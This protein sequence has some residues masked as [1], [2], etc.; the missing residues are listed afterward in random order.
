MKK[1]FIEHIAFLRSQGTFGILSVSGISGEFT[2]FTIERQWLENKENISRIPS[3]LYTLRID[4]FKGK[5]KNYK[6]LKVNNRTA[7]EMHIANFSSE[8]N[9]CIALGDSISWFSKEKRFGV[10]NSEK[11]FKKFMIAMNGDQEAILHI[12]GASEAML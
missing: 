4:T 12:F 8:L 5:Y 9:G 2:C 7:I 3:G 10:T 6:V 1:V 11:T